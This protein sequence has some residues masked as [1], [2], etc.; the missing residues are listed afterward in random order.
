MMVL[1]VLILLVLSFSLLVVV[2]DFQKPREYT[3][4]KQRQIGDQI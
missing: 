4:Q 1:L 3:G 2:V